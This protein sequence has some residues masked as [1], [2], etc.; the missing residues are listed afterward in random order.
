MSKREFLFFYGG[1]FYAILDSPEN[2][3]RLEKYTANEL[4]NMSAEIRDGLNNR[5][6]FIHPEDEQ[7]RRCSH[8][9]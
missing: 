6:E 7:I 3:E 9:L 2:F 8:I 1:N 5:Y 4:I